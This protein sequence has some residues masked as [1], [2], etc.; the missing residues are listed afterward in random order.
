MTD[1][2]Y[3]LRGLIGRGGQGEVLRALGSERTVRLRLL[4]PVPALL[5]YVLVSEYGA[6]HESLFATGVNAAVLN[7]GLVTLGA[8]TFWARSRGGCV[9]GQHGASGGRGTGLLGSPG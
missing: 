8:A 6:A 9:V 7:T 1:E 3:E 2:R 4:D 5:E